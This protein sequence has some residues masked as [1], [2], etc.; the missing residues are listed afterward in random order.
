MEV[1]TIE[2]FNRMLY[3]VVPALILVFGIGFFLTRSITNK[4]QRLME[5]ARAVAS[6]DFTRRTQISSRD[7]IGLLAQ[8]LDEM[9]DS[10]ANYTT[11]LQD[12]IDELIALYDSSSAVTIR[13]SLNM[14]HVLQA[15]TASVKTAMRSTAQVIIHLLDEERR[16]LIPKSYSLNAA[17]LP[18]FSYG[19]ENGLEKHLAIAR[20]QVISV[21]EI[22]CYAEGSIPT[23][24]VTKLIITP[25]IA[26]QETIGML[27]LVPIKD[28]SQ[29]NLLGADKERLLST[30]ANQTAISIK[31]AQLF[32][33]T[34]QAYEELR[35]LD[36][37]KTE[38]INIA[39]HE[40]RTPLGAMMGYASFAQKR[41]PPEL[42]KTM[43]FLVISS[44]RMRAM[45]D[46]MLTIQRLDMGTAL[47]QM[48]PTNLHTVVTK[49][50]ADIKAVADLQGHIITL[51]LPD[52]MDAI[53]A[54]PEKIDLILSNLI[55]NAIK[56]TPDQ[57]RIEVVVKDQH[58][59]VLIS[60]TDNGVGIPLEEQVRI[61]DRFYQVPVE[62]LGGHGG[63]G[64][65][66]T[67]VKHLVELHQGRVWVESEVGKGS[68]FFVELPRVHIALEVIDIKP[69]TQAKNSKTKI[70]M[71]AVK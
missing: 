23:L 42:R 12:R 63:M 49:T 25:L 50:I 59:T 31:N 39:A 9:T 69:D 51:D 68:T 55:S 61:F 43:D 52:T 6:G 33:A 62:H 30:L 36:D 19:S 28:N 66:L 57:G 44:M 47:I 41:V 34:Q 21:S 5:N 15:V 27:T 16:T 32:E 24:G 48:R 46:A 22:E 60:V 35:Q 26:G 2:A 40:L 38:F 13:S 7:E 70:E 18:P 20:P 11:E 53:E 71:V 58:D 65:G 67:A 4:L 64:I 8:S 1:R 17:C 56:F 54:D 14:D 29:S 10:L 45:V 37:L 3:L